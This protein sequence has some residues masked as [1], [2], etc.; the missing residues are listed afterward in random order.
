[1]TPE[2]AHFVWQLAGSFGLGGLIAAVITWVLCRHFF[3][4]YLSEKGKNLATQEDVASITKSLD[5]A[6]AEFASTLSY[7]GE[8]GKNLATKEDAAVI[9]R[10]I[11]S[12][13]SEYSM[14]SEQ[15]K[16]KHQMRIAALDRQ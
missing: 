13:K 8:K 7:F 16:A 15:F 4:S 9:A 14:L 3:S 10:E 5:S 1:M 12:V 6:K 11:E 2:D